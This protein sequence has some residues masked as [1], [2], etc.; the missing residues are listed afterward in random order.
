[1]KGYSDLVRSLTLLTHKNAPFVWTQECQPS[2]EALKEKRVSS[3]IMANPQDED[4]YF[5][6]ER[7]K[8]KKCPLE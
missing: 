8:R 5:P 2:F 6:A 4:L 7:A 1:M 3:E